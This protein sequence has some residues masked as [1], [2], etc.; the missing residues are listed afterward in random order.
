MGNTIPRV[1]RTISYRDE[2]APV[3]KLEVYNDDHGSGR[4]YTTTVAYSNLALVNAVLALLRGAGLVTTWTSESAW[5]AEMAESDPEDV[6]RGIFYV[7]DSKY[8]PDAR[9][10]AETAATIVAQAR[11]TLP[12]G[13]T[14]AGL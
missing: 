12:D 6:V 10:A 5:T 4:P 8:G 9:A 11:A 14:K 13:Q 3:R 7:P 1:P 2:G